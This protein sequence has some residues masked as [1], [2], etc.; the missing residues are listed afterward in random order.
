MVMGRSLMNLGLQE[1]LDEA[2]PILVQD[3]WRTWAR[4][5]TRQ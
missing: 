5:A 1:E 4:G 2:V 3:I